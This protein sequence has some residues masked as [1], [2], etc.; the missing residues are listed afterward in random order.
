MMYDC[1]VNEA[2]GT[3][4]GDPGATLTYISEDYAKRS[5]VHCVEGSKQRAVQLPNGNEM[6]ILGYCEFPMKMG[7]WSGWVQ[8]TILDIKAKFDVILGLAWYR[9]W[10]PIPDW[11]TLDMLVSTPEGVCRIEHK[12]RTEMRMPRRHRLTVMREYRKDLKFNL[13]SEKEAKRNLKQKGVRAMLYFVKAGQGVS[14]KPAQDLAINNLLREFA[15]VFRED[16]PEGLPPERD[17]EHAI[18]TGD[19]RPANRNPFPLSEQQLREQTRQVEGLLERGLIRES[20]SP[21]G[22]PVLFV[23]KKQPGEWRMCIDYRALNAR[24]LRNTYPLPRIQEC[25]DKLGNAQRLSSLDL[26]SG[27]W[28]LRVADKDIQKTAFN[29]RYGKYEFLVMPFGLTNAPATFQTLMNSI[30]RPRRHTS[31]LCSGG[32]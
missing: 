9:Q 13:I 31:S 28:Q 16:L 24:T 3:A 6:K 22:A 8:A 26:L 14:V 15:D 20:S 23:A 10:K 27:Y 29:T 7:E 2:K 12:L 21:W 32:T 30:L 18:D 4:L 25:I 1:E 19:T 11:D 5:N 17:I